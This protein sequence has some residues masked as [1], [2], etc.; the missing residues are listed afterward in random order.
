MVDADTGLWR[1]IPPSH[2]P[3]WQALFIAETACNPE[4]GDKA[5]WT[6]DFFSQMNARFPRIEGV[7]WF[8]VDKEHDWRIDETPATVAAIQRI[9]Q[10]GY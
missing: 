7:C 1:R 2:R 3:E 10:T 8:N 5:A 4:G 6:A 9:A